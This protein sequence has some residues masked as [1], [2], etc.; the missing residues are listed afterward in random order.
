MYG[1]Y[2]TIDGKPAVR[3]ERV[4]P[5]PVEHVWR[6]VTEPDELANWFPTTVD[7]DLREGG[8]MAFTFP[9]GEMD[10][11]DGSVV[12][13][14]PPRRFAFMWGTELLRFELAP[15]GEGTRL[16]L[17]HLISNSDEAARNAAG[18]HACLD[19]LGAVESD[20]EPLYEEYRRRGL[21]AGAVIPEHS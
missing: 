16:T 19:K 14:D 11:M 3:F 20:W 9:G 1:T 5:H 10:P 12:E 8:A 15:E 17:T 2:E 6:S 7:V 13:L 4:Y 18:W 21:P